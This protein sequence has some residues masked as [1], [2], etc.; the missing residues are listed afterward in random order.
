MPNAALV[1][2]A[3]VS[4]L[5][6]SPDGP[7]QV[8]SALP[9]ELDLRQARVATLVPQD[10]QD[11]A[12]VE[13][14]RRAWEPY[15]DQVRQAPSVRLRLPSGPHT[16]PLLL[17]AS[18]VLK[19]HSPTRLLYLSYEPNLDSLMD[20]RAWGALDGGVLTSRDLGTDPN[21][22]RILLARA[23]ELLPGRPWTLWVP[24]DPLAMTATLLGDGGRLVVPPGG[25]SARLAN[26][27]SAAPQDLEGGHGDL[28]LR[29][30]G[31]A[32]ARRWTFS[33]GEWQEGPLH[34]GRTEVQVLAREL[35]DIGG[36]LARMR[37]TQLRDRAALRHVESNMTVSMH[38]KE[39][40]GSGGD[41]TYVLRHFSR[42]GEPD[43]YL[44]VKVLSNGVPLKLHGNVM[45]P[46]VQAQA[47]LA[48]PVALAL[49]ERYRYADGG[50]AGPGQRW[51]RFE[52]VDQDVL[53]YR[54]KLKVDETTGR[55]LEEESS[56]SDLPGMV[57][58][59]KRHM[60][61]GEP[62]PGYWHLLSI[63]SHERWVMSNGI[64][65]VQND[66][67]HSDIQVNHPGF[68]AR[69]QEAY[70]SDQAMIRQTQGGLRYLAKQEDGTRKPLAKP[71][72]RMKAIGGFVLID[73]RQKP[74]VLPLA[75]WIL[76]D[77]DAL[78]KG[79]QYQLVTAVIWNHANL[80]LPKAFLGL[81]LTAQTTLSLF[82][83][84]DRPQREGKVADKEGVGR[85]TQDLSVGVGRDL[86]AGFRAELKGE[87]QYNRFTEAREE[88][89]RSPGYVLPASGLTRGL[90][91]R[92]TWHRGGF[93]LTGFGSRSQRP[94]GAYGLPGN[95]QTIPGGGVVFRTGGTVSYDHPLGQ[96]QWWNFGATAVDGRNMDRFNNL[97]GDGLVAGMRSDALT[98]N[99]ILK[100][101]TGFTFTTGPNLRLGLS[102]DAA[103]C[104]SLEDG[105]SYRLVGG[106]VS[107]DLPG[108]GWFSAV[109]VDLGVGLYSDIKGARGVQGMISLM[110]LF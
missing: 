58:S 97:G 11:P 45:L 56:R 92:L 36:L 43:D 10:S 61:Y 107:G 23:Q 48:A 21:Q 34:T 73:P 93:G 91:G 30:R 50:P 105:K 14:A 102:L 52:P 22:W 88:E 5:G 55:I 37:A 75:G 33:K 57:K 86:G 6:R 76:T 62:A 110:R 44:R 2:A 12:Q 29:L 106:K 109:R 83:F 20:E 17:A 96:Y 7:L 90:A 38:F 99:R 108:F 46:L 41:L 89:Y 49:T 1:L 80:T 85:S 78:G 60:V 42:L 15:L 53:L 54:G 98:A 72:T 13:A 82:P 31:E 28:T 32:K 9:V 94:T 81:D 18:Q 63:R 103:R 69:R 3:C 19:A 16:L 35:Y 87:F 67:R 64:A 100:A 40:M 71:A 4:L 84:T 59:E 77:F 104:R 39:D 27:L 95:L 74:Y 51:V 8:G 26:H 79:I 70:G 101:T 47:T 65:Q 25:P 66:I 68:E 24:S